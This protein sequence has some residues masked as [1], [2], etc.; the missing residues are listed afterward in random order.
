[1]NFLLTLIFVAG[2]TLFSGIIV[3]G[4]YLYVYSQSVYSDIDDPEKPA[5][6]ILSLEQ[7]D[8]NIRDTTTDA[9]DDQN[10]AITK[11]VPGK[12]GYAWGF[13]G[14]GS[15][16]FTQH[17]LLPS[18][19]ADFTLSM[20]FNPD[21]LSA[22]TEIIRQDYHPSIKK[23]SIELKQRYFESAK[24]LQLYK[25]YIDHN[26]FCESG[27][28]LIKTLEDI[29]RD[30]KPPEG[31]LTFDWEVYSCVK[32]N[33][34]DIYN[35]GEITS[36][37]NIISWGDGS[38]DNW[39]L[40][41]EG[42]LIAS[43]AIPENAWL[44]GL[45]AGGYGADSHFIEGLD[46]ISIN[47]WHHLVI[48]RD[49]GTDYFYL[50]GKL[51]TSVPSFDIRTNV[52]CDHKESSYIRLSDGTPL[53]MLCYDT[54]WYIGSRANGNE[55]FSGLLDQIL[56]YN[57]ALPATSVSG[58]SVATL[59]NDG[60]GDISPDT[61]NLA[62]HYD[63]EQTGTALTNIEAENFPFSIKVT[64][65]IAEHPG[66]LEL[67]SFGIETAIGL[68][69]DC[70]GPGTNKETY[71][72]IIDIHGQVLS[73]D[74]R[75]F[76]I[77]THEDKPLKTNTEYCVE[78]ESNW[79]GANLD[80]Q[81]MCLIFDESIA[82][83]EVSSEAQGGGCLIATAAFGSEMA[84][85]VQFLREIR[86]NTILQTESGTAFMTG[87]NQF[88]YSF[89]PAVADLERENPI[90]KEAVKVT[91]TPML[92]SLTLLNYVQ[93]DTEE[94]MLGYGIGIILLNVGMYFVAP[95]AS[96]IVIKNRIK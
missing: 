51:K 17:Q 5:P 15:R 79:P 88:Y 37:P 81:P 86:D 54:H 66:G 77:S 21:Q 89:S 45:H 24:I 16:V 60:V 87:F 76:V 43:A 67:D 58:N 85:Q 9:V 48:V 68:D 30:W 25:M 55:S 93:V 23:E 95:A 8:G 20:W 70:C 72:D 71:E 41:G 47:N 31:I 73:T 27:V 40:T 38:V 74:T 33:F 57:T 11:Q 1:M 29:E 62:V 64:W 19:I 46:N 78:V 59:W 14:E 69:V 39:A 34:Y 63:F 28:L 12:F 7:I 75:E 82:A 96:I 53:S 80:S 49:S 13:T 52:N 18:G 22:T 94:E 91:L 26:L 35:S 90:F 4:E 2:L 65:D 84:P 56:V 61:V 36:R 32:E 3:N 44:S 50:D 10:G 92:T 42:S 6:V 83:T